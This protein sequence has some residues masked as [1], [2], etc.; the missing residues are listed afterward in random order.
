MRHRVG[1]LPARRREGVETSLVA[2]GF[3]RQRLHQDLDVFL[4]E[5]AVGL[6]VAAVAGGMEVLAG[7]AVDAR[8]DADVDPP[9]GDL[10][11]GRDV[12]GQA[13][14]MPVGHD[15]A[16]LAETQP[17]AVAR[18]VGTQQQRVGA[19][20]VPAIPC[21][22]MLGQPQAGEAKLVDQLDGLVHLVE[23]RLP[24]IGIADVV[25]QCAVETHGRLNPLPRCG[26][27]TLQVVRQVVDTVPSVATANALCCIA[28]PMGTDRR[29]C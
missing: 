12:L 17:V 25:E 1:L 21:E 4:V 15:Q 6:A 18:A 24:G 28:Q 22:V 3:L 16:A 19:R 10:V 27:A 7:P 2:P 26:E 14:G 20:T 9:L 29:S 11:E 13:N 23:Q 5:R 8:R